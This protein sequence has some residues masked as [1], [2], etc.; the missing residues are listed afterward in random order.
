[1]RNRC[2]RL[3]VLAAALLAWNVP[4]AIAQDS[5]QAFRA[6]GQGAI[7]F[8]RDSLPP[9]LADVWDAY[10]EAW[11]GQVY[12]YYGAIGA[13]AP[14]PTPLAGWF[15]GTDSTMDT[16]INPNNGNSRG[17]DGF[18][19]FVF[20]TH[21]ADGWHITDGFTVQL[22]Q[23]VWTPN[24]SGMGKF[25]TYQA[26]GKLINGTGVFE[27]ATGDFT[28]QGDFTYHLAAPPFFS[29]WNPSLVGRF[30]K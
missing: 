9:V 5:C 30:C 26:S 29:A 20:G 14:K 1:M 17:R 28:L 19:V 23:A 13:S 16:V 7:T 3:F 18:Y 6:V 22:G 8:D 4:T 25:G 11:G 21:D 15:Y 2:V 27:G 10:P 12:A 24:P